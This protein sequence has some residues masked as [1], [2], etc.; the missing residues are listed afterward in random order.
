MLKDDHICRARLA[1]IVDG[2]PSVV[3]PKL[4]AL[5]LSSQQTT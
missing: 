4:R 3:C 1:H 2:Y 5:G